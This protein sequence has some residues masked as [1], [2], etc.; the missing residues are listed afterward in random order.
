[1]RRG[2]REPRTDRDDRTARPAG[3]EVRLPSSM[4]KRPSIRTC[5][6]PT[7]SVGGASK[8]EPAAAARMTRSMV[9][10]LRARALFLPRP[11]PQP[12]APPP[13]PRSSIAE[14]AGAEIED[15]A[16]RDQKNVRM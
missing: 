15:N 11:V 5:G 8:V 3:T 13:H 4:T 9:C 2:H 6:M 10:G 7:G 16:R 12:G 1:M 14:G